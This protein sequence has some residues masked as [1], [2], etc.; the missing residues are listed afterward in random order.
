VSFI[1]TSDIVFSVEHICF[2]F[3]HIQTPS[4]QRLLQTSYA[5]CQYKEETN[6]YM[7]IQN[8]LHISDVYGTMDTVLRH[9]DNDDDDDDDN[10]DCYLLY[11]G[12][13][14]LCT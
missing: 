2:M 8:L 5:K 7:T 10:Y 14:K 11:R 3:L 6:I 9:D 4:F 1:K 13:L 12:Y